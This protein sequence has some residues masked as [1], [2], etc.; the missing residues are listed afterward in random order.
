LKSV[1]QA[2]LENA[3]RVCEAKFGLCGCARAMASVPS[4]FTTCHLLM[5]SS[6]IASL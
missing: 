2:L 1:F 6:G 5:P 3:T 4:R